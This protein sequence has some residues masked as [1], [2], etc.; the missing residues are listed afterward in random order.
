MYVFAACSLHPHNRLYISSPGLPLVIES[1]GQTVQSGRAGPGLDVYKRKSVVLEISFYA[2]SRFISDGCQADGGGPRSRGRAAA[3]APLCG[4]GGFQAGGG[5]PRSR[6]RAAAAPLCGGGDS[7]AGGRNSIT[8]TRGGGGSSIRSEA[9]VQASD[10]V[11]EAPR[12]RH[13]QGRRASDARR[14]ASSDGDA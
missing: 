7:Q 12:R 9:L 11:P 8:S 6:G 14:H 10:G 3:A 1:P 5:G 4:G 13:F 2:P